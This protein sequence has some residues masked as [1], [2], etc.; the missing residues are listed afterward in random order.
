MDQKVDLKHYELFIDGKHVAPSTGEYTIDLD[1]STEEP[2]AEVAQGGKADVDLAVAAARAA[3]K[4]WGGLRA[5]ERGRILHRAASLLEQHQEELIEIESLD[6]R[7]AAQRSSPLQD[8]AAVIDTRCATTPD[9][10]IKSPGRSF[11]HVPMR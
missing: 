5:A 8:M 2:I 7:Q 6:G 4:V 9:G 11:P 3:L 1:P 10:A